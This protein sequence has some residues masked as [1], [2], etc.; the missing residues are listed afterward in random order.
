MSD[1]AFNPPASIDD[2]HASALRR[3]LDSARNWLRAFGFCAAVSLPFLHIP[4]LLSGLD[5]TADLSAFG[6]LLGSNLVA[7]IVGHEYR[8]A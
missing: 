1:S 6:V 2:D 5:S 7:L 8:P 4:L 3:G